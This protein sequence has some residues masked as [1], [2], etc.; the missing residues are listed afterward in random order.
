[1]V[2]ASQDQTRVGT[3]VKIIVIPNYYTTEQ[4]NSIN[5]AMFYMGTT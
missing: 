4:L 1:M 5:F 3:L 2:E